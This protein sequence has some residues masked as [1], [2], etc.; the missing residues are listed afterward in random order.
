[1]ECLETESFAL[2]KMYAKNKL[3]IA[4]KTDVNS[5][6]NAFKHS[7]ETIYIGDVN[8]FDLKKINYK[9]GS[10]ISNFVTKNKFYEFESEIRCLV[11]LGEDDCVSSRNVEVDLNE[12]IREVYV[13]PFAI[14]TGLLEVIEFLR[15][16][17]NLSY[18]IKESHIN[19]TW[20]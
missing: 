4:I 3:G 10:T 17:H 7:T 16:K 11:L 5:L 8:Y 14:E 19:D 15:D 18:A 12:L 20:L 6:I 9:L 2:W 13:S 1:M